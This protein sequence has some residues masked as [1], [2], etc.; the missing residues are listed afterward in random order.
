MEYIEPQCVVFVGRFE[1][2]RK[3]LLE[4]SFLIGDMRDYEHEFQDSQVFLTS[5][6]FLFLC[7]AFLQILLL[8]SLHSST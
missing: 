1:F 6:A 7:P 2:W 5:L 3:N 8:L 4:S